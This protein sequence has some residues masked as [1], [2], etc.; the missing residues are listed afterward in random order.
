M[1]KVNVVS[2]KPPSLMLCEKVEPVVSVV[3][4]NVFVGG[5]NR[6]KKR[7]LKIHIVFLVY[8]LISFTLPFDLF[9]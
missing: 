2:I 9:N 4:A 7:I 3:C 6:T 5:Q 1:V 8:P